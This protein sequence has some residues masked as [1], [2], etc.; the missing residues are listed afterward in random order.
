MR[1]LAPDT[2]D[3]LELAAGW[4]GKYDNYKWLDF[5][6]GVQQVSPV[7][8]KIMTQR[9]L[10]QFRIYTADE[11]D[12]P[13]GV[14]GLTNVDRHFKTASLWAVLGNK[15]FGGHTTEACHHMLTLGFSEL[16]LQAVNAW[17]VETNVPAQ[18]AL[19]QLHFRY[20]GRQRQCHYIDGRPLD[21]LLFDLLASEHQDPSHVRSQHDRAS[22]LHPVR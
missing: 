14:V 1:L 11:G 16:G 4:L 2:R 15:R 10:H 18:R 22:D 8:L 20:I 12:V 17:T 3:L 9:G 7:M 21:R 13:A 5:G 6:D 19:E